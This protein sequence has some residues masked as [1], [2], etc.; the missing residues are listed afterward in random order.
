MLFGGFFFFGGGGGGRAGGAM[1]P[2]KW[3]VVVH[4]VEG[5]IFEASFFF[6]FLSHELI[7]KG[8]NPGETNKNNS[9]RVCWFLNG[10][11]Y[12]YYYYY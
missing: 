4:A 3:L 11:S 10:A 1:K 5:F 7:A 9:C 12:Y 8:R 6:F 2:V